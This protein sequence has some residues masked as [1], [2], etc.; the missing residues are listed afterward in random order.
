V[1]RGAESIFGIKFV[2]RARRPFSF[3]AR[4]GGRWFVT[5]LGRGES[6]FA[7][8][9]GVTVEGDLGAEISRQR[10]N[11]AM[12]R[13]VRVIDGANIGEACFEFSALIGRELVE[14]CA[15]V[16]SE[17]GG[18]GKGRRINERRCIIIPDMSS[19]PKS[20]PCDHGGHI[21]GPMRR[22]LGIQRRNTPKRFALG[23][24]SLRKAPMKLRQN[25]KTVGAQ[26]SL[27]GALL[28]LLKMKTS[29]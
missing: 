7:G 15:V 4:F 22:G 28:E 27:N 12:A 25:G 14:A 5:G 18:G 13:S 17:R 11:F 1:Q 8:D 2:G 23:F 16:Q 21:G 29:G 26:R 10:L 3:S 24:C 20:R 9:E 19:R 6:H